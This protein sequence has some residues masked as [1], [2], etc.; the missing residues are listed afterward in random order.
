[1]SPIIDYLHTATHACSGARN[2]E[3][4]SPRCRRSSRA[5]CSSS[6]VHP[7]IHRTADTSTQDENAYSVSVSISVRGRDGKNPCEHITLTEIWPLS[8]PASARCVRIQRLM[9]R[10]RER[11][12]ERGGGVRGKVEKTSNH[13]G[14]KKIVVVYLKIHREFYPLVL[15]CV[16]L[17]VFSV[18]LLLEQ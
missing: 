2:A 5:L 6:G 7:S 9:E 4:H 18:S 17:F 12:R 3:M 10:K 11:E 14:Y 13:V 1:M 16:S 8:H 15:L